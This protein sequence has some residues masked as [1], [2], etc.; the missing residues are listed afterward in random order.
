MTA[1]P[2]HAQIVPPPASEVPIPVKPKTDTTDTLTAKRDSIKPP[3]GRFADPATYEIGPQYQW[4]RAQLFATG[5]LTVADL[6]DRI[7][8][9]NTFRSGWIATPQTATFN[10]DFRRV[11]IFYDGVE[12]D[13]LDNRVGGVLD[14]STVQLWTLEHLTIER[15]ASELRLYLRTWR[16]DNTDPY[17][18]V[19]VATGNEDTNLYRGFY[20]KR[21][22]NGGVLQ[23]AGQ[24]Y[25][26]T[27]SRF[28]GSGDALSLLGRIGIARQS[29]SIDAFVNRTRATRGIQRPAQGRPP[30]LSLDATTTNAYIR[31]AVGGVNSGPWAQATVASLGFKGRT[32]PDRNVTANPLA[33][34]LER[35]RS[36]TQ[37]NLSAGYTLGP[38][39]LEVQDRLRALGGA[40][41]NSVSGRLDVMTSFGVL[42]GFAERDGFRK[43]TNADLGLRLQPL[44]FISFAGSVGRLAPISESNPT[45]GSGSIATAT[46]VRGE[47][48]LKI[49][50][51]WFSVGMIS[52]DKT[53]GLAPVVYDTLLLPTAPGRITARTASIR[54]PLFGGLG[55][56][57]WVARWDRARPY[58]PEYQSRS[59]I[60]YAN[61]F[62]KRFPRG[63]FDVRAAVTYEYRGSTTFPL[64]A[65]DVRLVA[66]KTLSA[67]LEIRIIRAVVS[68][69]QRNILSYQ[70]AIIPGFEMP[71]VLAIYGVRWEFWN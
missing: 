30:V 36:E 67:L 31:A 5:A 59:E 43:I 2:A 3:I 57:A 54:G 38:A 32:D 19:D 17:T 55:I 8:G 58:Q 13:A 48:A 4:N 62:A 29:W 60:N 41:Y 65:G 52:A 53:Q 69:Q 44:P 1:S 64:D 66:A 12:L 63:D 51:P 37:Y 34:T 49:F 71:R 46:S 35:R 61:N 68:Y 11:R 14:L 28:A 40:T 22:D 25:G 9:A 27:S 7:P 47:A 50:G 10:A 45:S 6:L 56:D 15:S 39:R 20:G 18:R 23:L 70:Y 24:Q 42:S 21:F 33:D 16:V 26:V